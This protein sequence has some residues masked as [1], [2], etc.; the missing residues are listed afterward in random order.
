MKL[1]ARQLPKKS[2][3]SHAD[4]CL[5]P[6][7]RSGRNR[8][9]YNPMAT[10]LDKMRNGFINHARAGRDEQRRRRQPYG[11]A[12]GKPRAGGLPDLQVACAE[13]WGCLDTDASAPLFWSLLYLMHYITFTECDEDA[14][15]DDDSD[16]A[17]FLHAP[18]QGGSGH[19]GGSS[20]GQGGSCSLVVK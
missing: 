5:P 11:S 16:E 8:F 9:L 10:R 19:G 3:Y 18:K 14:D 20:D 2:H 1:H 4:K 12:V 6:M 15:D 7:E 17:D 13:L